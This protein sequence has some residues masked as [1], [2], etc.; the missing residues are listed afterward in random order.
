MQP[1]LSVFDTRFDAD[2]MVAK[3]TTG[4]NEDAERLQRTFQDR[5]NLITGNR[6]NVFVEVPSITRRLDLFQQ[7]ASKLHSSTM[8]SANFGFQPEIQPQQFYTPQRY[9]T[10]GPLSP[11]NAQPSMRSY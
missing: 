8:Q 1:K 6:I 7:T 11:T 4:N 10:Q 5:V 3:F 9:P 2:S